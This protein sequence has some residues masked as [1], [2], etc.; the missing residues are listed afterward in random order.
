[1]PVS[2]QRA[3]RPPRMCSIITGTTAHSTISVATT[4]PAMC[5]IASDELMPDRRPENRLHEESGDRER[6]RRRTTVRPVADP[7]AQP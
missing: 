1:M 3:R 4:A 6:L 5:G 7:P 2:A